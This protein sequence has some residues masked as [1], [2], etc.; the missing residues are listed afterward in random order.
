VSTLSYRPPGGRSHFAELLAQRFKGGQEIGRI[1][2][3]ELSRLRQQTAGLP[4]PHGYSHL[5]GG[6]DAIP[7]ATTVPKTV[8]RGGTASIG[9][10]PGYMMEDAQLVVPAIVTALG[11]LYTH[12]GSGPV[13]LPAS[14]PYTV[15]RVNPDGSLG[16]AAMSVKSLYSFAEHEWRDQFIAPTVDASEAGVLV[17]THI[18]Q[19]AWRGPLYAQVTDLVGEAAHPG[20][21]NVASD[22]AVGSSTPVHL[23]SVVMADI[24]QTTAI[25]RIPDVSDAGFRFGLLRTLGGTGNASEGNY[26]AYLASASP[27]W[28]AVTRDGG[29]IT[30]TDTG[31]P[32]VAGDWYLLEL[33][34]NDNT[35]GQKDFYIN[36]ALGASNSTNV[37]VRDGLP[38]YEIETEDVGVAKTVDVDLFWMTTIAPLG[39]QYP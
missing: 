20:I 34:E 33:Y 3:D 16:W 21:V 37:E 23:G 8:L 26:F 25:V 17:G 4:F 19:L 24:Y 5:Q 18:G 22:V 10:G 35:P 32:V 38:A 15:L 39:A 1:L 9:N 30:A 29:G 28:L 11:D 13:A 36:G 7:K 6:K 31:V 12:D 27:N 2:D 14:D